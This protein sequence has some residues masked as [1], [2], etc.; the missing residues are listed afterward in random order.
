MLNAHTIPQNITFQQI[1]SSFFFRSCFKKRKNLKKKLWM[2]K[3]KICFCKNMNGKGVKNV[4]ISVENYNFLECFKQN[5]VSIPW[6]YWSSDFSEGEIIH[7]VQKRSVF[8]FTLEFIRFN[9]I[10]LEFIG[11]NRILLEFIK[12]LGFIWNS[13]LINSAL[14]SFLGRFWPL[15]YLFDRSSRKWKKY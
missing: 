6:K 1:F 13:L 14:V 11:F 9:G 10:I 3:R 8:D 2:K 4:A 5:K 15:V 12:K 7:R